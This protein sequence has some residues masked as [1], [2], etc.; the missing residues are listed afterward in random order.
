MKND[1]LVFKV[2][3]ISKNTLKLQAYDGGKLENII[4]QFKAITQ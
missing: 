4:V 1:Y 2:V 3:E